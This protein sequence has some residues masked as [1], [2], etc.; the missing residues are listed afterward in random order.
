MIS[1]YLLPDS[2][3]W[4]FMATGRRTIPRTKWLEITETLKAGLGLAKDG[5]QRFRSRH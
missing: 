5:L 2:I 1:I 4:L 3:G